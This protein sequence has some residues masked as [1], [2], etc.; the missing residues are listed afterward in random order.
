MKCL[1]NSYLKNQ[2]NLSNLFLYQRIEFNSD[3]ALQIQASA[4]SSTKNDAPSTR[5]MEKDIFLLE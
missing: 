5:L 1:K 4:S 3:E 2:G